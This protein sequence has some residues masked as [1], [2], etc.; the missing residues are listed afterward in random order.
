MHTRLTGRPV[1]CNQEARL[2]TEAVARELALPC[3]SFNVVLALKIDGELEPSIATRAVAL[4][5]SRHG[6]L[7]SR[8]IPSARISERERR[9]QLLTFGSTAILQP[10]LFECAESRTTTP[11]LTTKHL[12]TAPDLETAVS[13][14]I[15]ADAATPFDYAQ[16]PLIRGTVF[17]CGADERVLVLV[18]AHLVADGVSLDILCRELIAI[19]AALAESR[20]LELPEIER[21]YWQIVADEQMRECSGGNAKETAYWAQQWSVVEN[22][23]EKGRDAWPELL[24]GETSSRRPDYSVQHLALSPTLSSAL[25]ALAQA[26]RATIDMVFRACLLLTV[27]RMARRS[28]PSI[29]CSYANRCAETRSTVGWLSN[30]HALTVHAGDARSSIELIRDVRVATLEGLAHQSLSPFMLWRHLGRNIERERMRCQIAL[31][32]QVTRHIDV[33]RLRF[34]R[35]MLP[36]GQWARIA[37]LDVRIVINDGH[38]ETFLKYRCD[39]FHHDTIAAILGEFETVAL[40]MTKAP[41][42]TLSL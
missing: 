29:L 31:N 41:N 13:R 8:F 2:L 33:G 15:E 5:L 24:S 28:T 19:V 12:D 32:V 10:G 42:R 39:R 26:N 11:E 40:T 38:A 35:L 18:V 9:N 4:L 7:R 30:R 21:E 20:N 1:R 37:D 3:P 23:Y 27:A 14:A 16:P 25:R 17:E 22:G 36:R 6:Q 34:R